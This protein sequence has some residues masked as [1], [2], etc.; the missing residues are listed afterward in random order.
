MVSRFSDRR[1]ILRAAQIG[2][3]IVLDEVYGELDTDM[4]PLLTR[5]QQSDA[6]AFFTHCRHP[7]LDAHPRAGA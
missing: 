7:T 5:V 6:Q 4:T 1:Y 3:P 2:L